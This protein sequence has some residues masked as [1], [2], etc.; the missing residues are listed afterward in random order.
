[1]RL[2]ALDCNPSES[3]SFAGISSPRSPRLCAHP[4]KRGIGFRP[5]ALSCDH[6]EL[7]ILARFFRLCFLC[8]LMFNSFWLRLAAPRP[9]AFAFT[10]PAGASPIFPFLPVD[11]RRGFGNFTAPLMVI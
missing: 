5:A 3:L 4:G 8:L 9:G 6:R 2:A 1:L 11:F 10:P 7:R